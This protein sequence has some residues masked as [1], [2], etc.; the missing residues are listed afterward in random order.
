MSKRLILTVVID[1]QP[2]H[3]HA[4]ELMK[5]Y[6]ERVSADLQIITRKIGFPHLSPHWEL[7][8]QMKKLS[9]QG[10]YREFLFLD[11]DILIN[12]SAHD[13]FLFEQL[14]LFREDKGDWG[15]PEGLKHL[16][17]WCLE[18]F[19]SAFSE[20]LRYYYNTGMIRIGRDDLRTLVGGFREPFQEFLY[21]QHYLN[22][23]FNFLRLKI[24]PLPKTFNYISPHFEQLNLNR[25]FVHMAAKGHDT[26]NRYAQIIADHWL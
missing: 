7:L 14:S 2:Y 16:R 25:S 22:Y 20:D 17:E 4:I 1:F 21:E 18:H 9:E 12:P 8:H 24:F 26:R 3:H 19:N 10:H 5:R 11:S 23:L 6:A 15:S 13:I